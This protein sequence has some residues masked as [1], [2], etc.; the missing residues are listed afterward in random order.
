MATF[1]KYMLMWPRLPKPV[2]LLLTAC[3]FVLSLNPLAPAAHADTAAAMTLR[4]LHTNDHHGHLEP[5]QVGGESLGGVARRSRLIAL[6]RAESEQSSQPLL[7]LDAGDVFQGTKFF[8]HYEGQ[9]DLGFY[10]AMG[11]DAMSVGNHEFDRGDAPLAA[12]AG[13]ARFPLLSANLRAALPS[14]LVGKIRPWVILERAGLRIGIFGL[15]TPHTAWLSSP[16][17][18]VTFN[19]PTVAAE[20]SV[21]E[22]QSRGVSVIIA[23]THLGMEDEL[24]LL[25]RVGGIDVMV[26]GHSHTRLSHDGLPYPRV[27]SRADGSAAVYATAWE[28]GLVVGDLQAQL[29]HQGNLIRA[30]GREIRVDATIAPDPDVEARIAELA[31]R[32][33]P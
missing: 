28:F 12:F 21:R 24:K 22:L 23:L 29:D 20:Q 4:I 19:D 11:Y 31:R 6:A 3:L 32:M 18:G 9:A 16:G 2:L 26:G 25:R 30:S 7:L 27:I 33:A 13:G 8:D 10:N 5:L 17:R 1:T 15:T 14:P